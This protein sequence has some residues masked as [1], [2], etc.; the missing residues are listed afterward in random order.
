L[1]IRLHSQNTILITTSHRP[2]PQ[3]RLLVKFLKRIINNSILLNRGSR[4]ITQLTDECKE[5]NAKYILILDSKGNKVNNIEFYDVI[6]GKL[7]KYPFKIKI[8]EYIDHRIF[9]WKKLPLN[10]GFTAP[11]IIFQN[12]NQFQEI[13]DKYFRLQHN[14]EGNYWL[15]LDDVKSKTNLIIQIVDSIT[16]RKFLFA[17]LKLITTQDEK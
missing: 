17:R 13:L 4:S 14:K 3:T 2:S 1:T 6:D 16:L 8:N 5:K 7:V 12:Q 10:T 15:L 11:E 9:G